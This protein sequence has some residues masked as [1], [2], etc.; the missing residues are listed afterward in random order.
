MKEVNFLINFKLFEDTQLI[1]I[2]VSTANM[3]QE[4]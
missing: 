4:N 3:K 1:Q 2:L